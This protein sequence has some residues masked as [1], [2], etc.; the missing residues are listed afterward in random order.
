MNQFA[1]HVGAG[2]AIDLL[3]SFNAQQLVDAGANP[4]RV[5]DGTASLI[6]TTE[7]PLHPQN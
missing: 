2:N 4:T 5:A 7:N 1:A 6:P 3:G